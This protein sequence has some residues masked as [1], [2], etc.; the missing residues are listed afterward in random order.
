[1]VREI[2]PD[3]VC[4]N[5]GSCTVEGHPDA[6]TREAMHQVQSGIDWIARCLTCGVEF[7]VRVDGGGEYDG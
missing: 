3:A 1:M 5:C 6:F 4:P 7:T 2:L